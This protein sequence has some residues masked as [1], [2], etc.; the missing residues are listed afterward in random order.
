MREYA[1]GTRFVSNLHLRRD[2]FAAR[3]IRAAF[4]NCESR[5]EGKDEEQRFPAGIGARTWLFQFYICPGTREKNA[6]SLSFE[7]DI[8]EERR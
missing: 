1:C 2:I 8:E 3:E 5:S 7:M 4:K 6:R